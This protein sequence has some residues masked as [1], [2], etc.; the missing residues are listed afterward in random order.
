MLDADAISIRFG[1]RQLFGVVNACW[2]VIQST[3]GKACEKNKIDDA[4]K[5]QSS[6][7]GSD[8]QERYN[9]RLSCITEPS[10]LV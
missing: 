10:F 4:E 5:I 6:C 7:Q 9:S 8:V 3:L 2:N 1:P